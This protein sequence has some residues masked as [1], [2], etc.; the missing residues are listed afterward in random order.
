MRVRASPPFF[1]IPSMSD[2]KNIAVIRTDRLGDMVL[3]LPMFPVLRERFPAAHLTLIASRYVEPLVRHLDCID[4]VVY[5]DHPKAD[6]GPI[7]HARAIDTLFAPRPRFSEA[8][9]ALRAGVARRVGSGYRWYSPLYNV[10]IREHRSDATCHEAEYNIRMIMHA[11]GDPMPEVRLVSPLPEQAARPW[12]ER[13]IVVVHP[14]SGGSAKDWPAQRFGLAAQ[15]IAR[16]LDAEIIVTGLAAERELC[17]LVLAACPEATDRCGEL[18]LAS[19]I[20]LLSGADL[21][22]ANSTGVLHIAAALGVAVVGFF[23]CTPSMSARR[24][25]PYTERAIVLESGLGDDMLTITV[26][27]AVAAAEMLLTPR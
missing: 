7:L 20:K 26:D 11:F 10:R 27:D 14:G 6:I 15:R 25:G 13:P 9:Q 1:L 19:M 3:T 23:P 4:E 12:R 5:L 24:W 2:P 16:E 22:L 21:L 8:W 18:D 17:D